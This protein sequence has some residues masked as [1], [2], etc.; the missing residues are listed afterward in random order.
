M[1][2]YSYLDSGRPLLATRLPTHTQVLDD[3][4]ACLVEPEPE[5]FARG[6]VRLLTS[7]PLR[8]RLAANA[9]ELALREFTPAAFAAKLQ[10]F[11]E[12]VA[13]KLA[14]GRADAAPPR[15]LPVE[16]HS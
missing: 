2:V 7:E 5:A 9:R 13:R 12:A 11:Y 4:V 16:F 6:L 1:K 10:R 3:E 14:N 8:E 15:R